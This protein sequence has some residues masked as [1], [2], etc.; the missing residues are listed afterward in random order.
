MFVKHVVNPL[1]DYRIEL[2]TKV[3]HINPPKLSNVEVLKRMVLENGGV[4][5]FIQGQMD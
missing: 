3:R 4:D 5:I 2:D 1:H